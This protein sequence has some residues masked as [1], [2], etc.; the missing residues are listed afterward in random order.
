MR[1]KRISH[2]L[3]V[4]LVVGAT[5]AFATPSHAQ[6]IGGR[7]TSINKPEEPSVQ[8]P[9]DLPTFMTSINY[10][11]VYGAYAVWP[12]AIPVTFSNGSGLPARLNDISMR[13][14]PV[15]TKAYAPSLA[16]PA[17][18]ALVNVSLPAGAEL[19]FEGMQ[20]PGGGTIRKFTSPELDPL[21][22]YTY[23]VRA[24]WYENGKIVTQSQRLLVRA[25]DR[26]TVNFPNAPA[27]EQG[28]TLRT[29][30]PERVDLPPE[31]LL[32]R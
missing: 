3:T 18:A 23:D 22:A 15:V 12:Y 17:T 31:P 4:A 9:S 7:M 5:L 21:K 6:L 13:P 8:L 27:V 11:L 25:G 28:P 20:V 30:G 1:S 32:R 24:S 2:L 14:T 10:P 19:W 26:L 29:S 16:P